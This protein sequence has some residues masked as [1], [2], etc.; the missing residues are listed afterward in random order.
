[1][2]EN[3]FANAN[4]QNNINIFNLHKKSPIS[5]NTFSN[6]LSNEG[7]KTLGYTD[8]S[9][10]I[11]ELPPMEEDIDHLKN[12]NLQNR[13]NIYNFNNLSATHNLT[14]IKNSNRSFSVK[15]NNFHNEIMNKTHMP[16]KTDLFFMNKQ[17]NLKSGFLLNNNDNPRDNLPAKALKSRYSSASEN[18]YHFMHKLASNPQIIFSNNS[19]PLDIK[20]VN[21]A[22]IK[23]TDSNKA[24]N[25]INNNSGTKYYYNNNNMEHLYSDKSQSQF[26]TPQSANQNIINNNIQTNQFSEQENKFKQVSNYGYKTLN[27][28][29]IQNNI[30]LVKV[31]ENKSAQVPNKIMNNNKIISDFNIIGNVTNNNINNYYQQAKTPNYYNT[32]RLT[33][34]ANSKKI[35]QP[36]NNMNLNIQRNTFNQSN[37]NYLNSYFNI[38]NNPSTAQ[39]K[40]LINFKQTI[41][42]IEVQDKEPEI[43][44][45][46]KITDFPATNNINKNDNLFY[47]QLFGG[48]NNNL[49][50]KQLNNNIPIQNNN[51]I[52]INFIQN[53]INN[54]NIKNQNDLISKPLPANY[55]PEDIKKLLNQDITQ[56]ISDKQPKDHQKKYIPPIPTVTNNKKTQQNPVAQNQKLINEYRTSKDTSIPNNINLN[57]QNFT[58]LNLFSNQIPVNN[59]NYIEYDKPETER[60]TVTNDKIQNPKKPLANK[61]V[62][63]TYNDFDGS[64]YVKNYGGVSRPGKDSSGRQKTN[65]DALVCQTN[66]NNIKDFNIFGVLDG[67]GPDG[68]YVSQFAAEFIPSNIVN[69]PEIKSLKE[70]EK[71][72]QKLKENNCDIIT[73]AFIFA[74]AQLKSVDFDAFESGTTCCLIIHVGTHIICA[75]AG[76][77]RALVVFDNPANTNKEN[78]NYWNVTPLSMDYKPEMPEEMNRIIMAGGVVKQMEDSLGEGCGPYRV[79]VKG[80]DYPGLA[81]SR[82]IGDLKGKEIGVI[83]NPGILEYDLNKS[84]RYVIACSDGVFEFLN[85]KTVMEVGKSFFLQNDASTYC[86]ELVTRS[87]IEWETNDNI[88]DDITAVVAFF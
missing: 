87:L 2:K 32:Q 25:N 77:S 79:W 67:H 44:V 28:R 72:Y 5:N 69:H 16:R 70:P 45:V 54:I 11:E 55:I 73:Q 62:D 31:N 39:E 18:K 56:Y 76:D 23:P 53:N 50:N 83:P 74:D 20:R 14:Q 38:K 41:K 22:P 29:K 6:S 65:Q 80:K 78:L 58:N 43:A 3:Y 61:D 51:N 66:I 19:L 13:N 59:N 40:N 34:V 57:T 48:N 30:Q 46:T 47:E 52:N 64:G 4:I 10:G 24:Y 7:N 85:N 26:S 60:A 86:H 82:S 35:N 75:N 81:M 63:V 42:N 9:V 1:M 27:V 84:T 49:K 15:E 68:H 8:E 21:Y 12:F 71:I 33:N 88:V 37:N 36:I 17:N